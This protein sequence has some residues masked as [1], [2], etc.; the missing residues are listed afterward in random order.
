MEDHTTCRICFLHLNATERRP[1]TLTCGH[2][3][4]EKCR[5][6]II[7]KSNLCPFCKV[8]FDPNTLTINFA[9]K[10]ALPILADSQKVQKGGFKEAIT[11]G[12][13]ISP[14]HVKVKLDSPGPWSPK[15]HLAGHVPA[16]LNPTPQ[17]ECPYHPSLP[18][19]WFIKGGKQACM[20]C[21]KLKNSSWGHWKCSRGC[22]YQACT[23]CK[24]PT[25]KSCPGHLQYNLRWG[26]QIPLQISEYNTYDGVQCHSC[27]NFHSVENTLEC[28]SGCIICRECS[29]SSPH[30]GKT[31]GSCSFWCVILALA[32]LACLAPLRTCCIQCSV[33]ER[34]GIERCGTGDYLLHAPWCKCCG[35]SCCLGKRK[36]CTAR[37]CSS[38]LSGNY[39]P[40]TGHKANILTPLRTNPEPRL[41]CSKCKTSFVPSDGFHFCGRGDMV[42]CSK[43]FM[44]PINMC[45]THNKTK[46]KLMTLGEVIP[47][48]MEDNVKYCKVCGRTEPTW[49][50]RGEECDFTLCEKCGIRPLFCPNHK[51]ISFAYNGEETEYEEIFCCICS[52]DRPGFGSFSCPKG[53]YNVCEECYYLHSSSPVAHKNTNKYCVIHQ[54]MLTQRKGGT[55]KCLNCTHSCGGDLKAFECPKGHNYTICA[56]CHNHKI[57]QRT[58]LTCCPIHLKARMEL[59]AGKGVKYIKCGKCKN[60]KETTAGYYLCEEGDYKICKQC[61][62]KTTP[63]RK[64]GSSPHGSGYKS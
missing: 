22:D 15:S 51:T 37:V 2:T 30:L 44:Y 41:L 12:S 3:I 54:E 59:K 40:T 32:P 26:S 48:D 47:G 11:E 31:T 36:T 63:R 38:C 8:P 55:A 10:D 42:L 62:M 28:K 34:R 56:K 24:P 52:K 18:M 1:V 49:R 7:Q 43:C 33:C 13:L 45:K 58:D 64:R 60:R 6:V 19:E 53:D 27:S 46:E 25:W 29:V 16:D 17:I 20:R 39:C 4:C 5:F 50:C 14:K 35:G 57:G 61:R 9:L 21:K 23:K